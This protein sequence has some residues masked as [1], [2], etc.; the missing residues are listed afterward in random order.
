MFEFIQRNKKIM[1]I[2][3]IIL[4]FPSFVLFGVD[5]YQRFNENNAVAARI[6]GREISVA[7][8]E[9]AH[10]NEVDRMRASMPGMDVAMFDTPAM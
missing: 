9:Q 7:E 1:Q 2:L 6:D 4:I 3:L 5:G 10:K 8:W